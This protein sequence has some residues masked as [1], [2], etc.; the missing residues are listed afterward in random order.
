MWAQSSRHGE[1]MM[2]GGHDVR[3]RTRCGRGSAHSAG[4][5]P[6]Q[7]QVRSKSRPASLL[8]RRAEAAPGSAVDHAKQG[9]CEALCA[10]L[11]PLGI[12]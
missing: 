1:G 2:N 7:S 12:G 5:G 3:W 4:P 11:L 8:I 6:V 9:K 10:I